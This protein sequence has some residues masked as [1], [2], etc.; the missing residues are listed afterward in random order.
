[1]RHTTHVLGKAVAMSRL[2]AEDCTRGSSNS[3]CTGEGRVLFHLV[4]M[5]S[6]SRNVF[7][8]KVLIHERYVNTPTH[9]YL[10][11]GFQSFCLI[12]LS[13][14]T[15]EHAMPFQ[16]AHANALSYST[17]SLHVKHLWDY[18]H[19][20]LA[21]YIHLKGMVLQHFI[22]FSLIKFACCDVLP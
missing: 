15:Q 16:M 1:M 2:Q 9:A 19:H 20:Q 8:T 7:L 11:L 18:I 6:R 5:V 13:H 14:R 4:T 10:E 12:P 17:H 21:S 3:Q 22:R